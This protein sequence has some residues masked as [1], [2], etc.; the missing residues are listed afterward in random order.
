MDNQARAG[1][2]ATTRIFQRVG[3]DVTPPGDTTF[4]FVVLRANTSKRALVRLRLNVQ[5]ALRMRACMCE[6]L[7]GCMDVCMYVC[8]YVC[9]FSMIDTC[10]RTIAHTYRH[11]P[12]S[13]VLQACV[14][15]YCTL[16]KPYSML[17][18][19]HIAG[20][21]RNSSDEIKTEVPSNVVVSYVPEAVPVHPVHI[22]PL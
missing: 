15:T 12:I 21:H 6:C 22:H 3:A 4:F 20:A 14:R 7:Y 18:R 2:P 11:M 5:V 9:I 8:M 19:E 17:T 13:T 16:V 10:A 1:W